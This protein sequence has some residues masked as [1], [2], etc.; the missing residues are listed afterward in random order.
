MS[1]SLI[2]VRACL[3]NREKAEPKKKTCSPVI[4]EMSSKQQQG[5]IYFTAFDTLKGIPV[6]I[7]LLAVG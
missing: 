7:K 6:L 5:S 2:P 4:V 3:E 1:N